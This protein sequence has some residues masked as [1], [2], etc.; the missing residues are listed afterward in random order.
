M[1]NERVILIDN[2]D[3]PAS[4]RH[5]ELIIHKFPFRIGRSMTDGESHRHFDLQENDL[6][7]KESG[8]PFHASRNH[9]ELGFSGGSV[10][11]RD[12]G[13]ANGTLVNGMRIGGQRGEQATLLL[14][15]EN[16][17]IQIGKNKSPWKFEL[18]IPQRKERYRMVI[19]DDDVE[20]RDLLES[21]FSDDF[22]IILAKDGEEALE[23]CLAEVPDIV[24]LDWDMPKIQGIDVCKTLKCNLKTSN[25]PIVMLTGRAE[26]IDRITG[27]EVGA[28]DYITKP[29]ELEELKTRVNGALSRVLHARDVHWLTGIASEAAFRNEVNDLL[30]SA[31]EKKEFGLI[32][33]TLQNLGTMDWE[34]GE[35][36]TDTMVR[37]IA[38]AL[39]G[40]TVKAERTVVGQLRI[41]Q[42]GILTPKITRKQVE[43]SIKANLNP[44]IKD[45]PLKFTA[46][47][48]A[49]SS[50]QSYHDFVDLI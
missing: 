44:I 19:A 20:M 47:Y 35:K 3:V 43:K 49:S 12:L 21:I 15:V 48:Y 24:I 38:E 1:N 46:K 32:K 18:R 45:T 42:W 13:S 40:E 33:V 36:A 29:P 30:S 8:N 14:Q 9:V 39:W 6:Y 11:I 16:N 2:S 23:R 37:R 41:G 4:Q 26:S 34:V 28:D 31:T 25:L 10:Y 22:D 50:G 27:I 17:I 7:L 5:V